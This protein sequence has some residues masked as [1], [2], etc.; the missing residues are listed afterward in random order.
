M[1][2]YP[3]RLKLALLCACAAIG[4]ACGALSYEKK[5]AAMTPWQQ[6]QKI[7]FDKRTGSTKFKAIIDSCTIG[8]LAFGISAAAGAAALKFRKR[9]KK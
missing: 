5:R 3:A 8:A 9:H 4:A 7:D 6:E 1:K 2:K